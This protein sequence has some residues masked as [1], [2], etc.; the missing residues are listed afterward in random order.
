MSSTR[1]TVR[2]ASG[3]CGKPAVHTFVA[4][5]GETFGECVE[6]YVPVER[7]SYGHRLG[8]AVEIKRYGKT[9]T[10]RVVEI[11]KRGAIYAEFR[12]DN[13]ATRRVRVSS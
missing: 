9:Y 1:C 8:D 12:Y 4:R 3:V 2:N 5:S 11:G 10:G 7:A 13:G 6:H